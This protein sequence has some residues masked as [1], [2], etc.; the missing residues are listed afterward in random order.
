MNWF[1]D[2]KFWKLFYEWMFPKELFDEAI[3]QVDKIQQ[4]TKIDSGNLLDLCCGPGRFSIPFSKSGFKVTA[5]D[6]TTFLLD[7]AK[8]YSIEQNTKIDFIMANMLEYKKE[9]CFDL[10]ISMYSSFGYFP[11]RNDDQKVLVNMYESLKKGGKVLIDLRGKE[12]D[13]RSFENTKSYILENGDIVV[14]IN[15]KNN[16]SRLIESKWI[17]IKGRVAEHFELILNLY[18]ADEIKRLLLKTGF[19]K[20]ECYGDLSGSNY[21]SNATR[22]VVIAEK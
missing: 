22:L 16:N 13:D 2:I 21:D 9:N 15:N 7:K 14:Q 11:D 12:I 8:E 17:Y 20:V 4:L 10:I 6:L 19:N 1:E 5:V 18:S 3:I